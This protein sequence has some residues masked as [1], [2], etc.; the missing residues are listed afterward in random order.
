MR[1]LF[2]ILLLTSC[3]STEPEYIVISP[4]PGAMS[5]ESES[6]AFGQSWSTETYFLSMIQD[7]L[8]MEHGFIVVK[9]KRTHKDENKAYQIL[10]LYNEVLRMECVDIASGAWDDN[11]KKHILKTRNLARQANTDLREHVRIHIE[12]GALLTGISENATLSYNP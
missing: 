6:G 10:D 7:D 5:F 11:Q 2:F 8:K 3:A 1:N 12:S 9:L 4:E